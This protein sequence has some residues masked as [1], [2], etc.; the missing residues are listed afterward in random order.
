MTRGGLVEL[1]VLAERRERT[2]KGVVAGLDYLYTRYGSGDLTWPQ[3]VEPA[4]RYAE[5]GFR[6]DQALPSS[7]AEGAVADITVFDPATIT[8]R[9]TYENPHQFAV[10]VDHVIIN[11]VLVFRDGSLTGA[12]PGS[13][14]RRTS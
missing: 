7:I 4:I 6:L 14:L 1:A 13:V 11:G 10:G 9:S 3:L 5:E 12:R 8:D 2:G